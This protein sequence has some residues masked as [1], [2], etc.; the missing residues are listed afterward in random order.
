[1]KPESDKCE[2]TNAGARER[3]RGG[4]VE[5]EPRVEEEVED[6]PAAPRLQPVTSCSI[7]QRSSSSSSKAHSFTHINR[8]RNRNLIWKSSTVF[9][10]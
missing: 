6:P 9:S 5:G 4:G 1:M 2:E 8:R 7:S 3:G 10:R